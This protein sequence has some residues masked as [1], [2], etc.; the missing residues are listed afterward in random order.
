MRKKYLTIEERWL[1]DI[2]AAKDGGTFIASIPQCEICKYRIKNNAMKCEKYSQRKP[3]ETLRCK[4]ECPEF[5]SSDVLEMCPKTKFDN[6]LM[7]GIF[8]FCVGDA[9]GVPVEFSTRA[10]RKQDPV[11]EMRAYGTH[12]QYFGT[13]SDDSSLTF[14]LMESL[15]VGYNLK[16]ISEKF[17]QFYE[18]G[19]WTAYSEVF[20]IGNTTIRSIEKMKTASNPT[21]CGGNKEQDNG[22]G[23]LMRILPL[24]FYLRDKSEEEKK[25][26]L[27]LFLL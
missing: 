4:K 2:E 5:K 25:I 7:G 16:D 14:C 20:D 11:E 22:N 24:A 23:S 3:K 19:Y 26:K 12:H 9:L 8:G 18:E 10:E 6:Q 17:C 1:Q 15:K 27:K 21:E 13:W